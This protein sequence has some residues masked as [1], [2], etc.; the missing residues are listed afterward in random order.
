MTA[1]GKTLEVRQIRSG[2]GYDTRQKATLRALGL[3][4]V[5]RVRILP[6]NQ[7]VRGMLSKIPHLVEVKQGSGEEQ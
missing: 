7:Q 4:K 3:A 6:D 5:G 2:I 1:K